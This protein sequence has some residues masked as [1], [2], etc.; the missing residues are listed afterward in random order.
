M[1]ADM[2]PFDEVRRVVPDIRYICIRKTNSIEH[3]RFY[4]LKELSEC[5]TDEEYHEVIRA[6]AKILK[7]NMK[8]VAMKWKKP[9]IS[10]TGGI[11]SNTTFAAAN[12]NYDKFKAF[13][14]VSAPK[15]TIDADAAKRI[16]ER[17]NVPYIRFDIPQSGDKLKDYTEICQIALLRACI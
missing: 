1:P 8:L 5:R 15:E 16:A 11:D 4:P 6:G 9:Y 13:S 17:F 7:N 14:Y 12:G 10:L 3:S 2:T